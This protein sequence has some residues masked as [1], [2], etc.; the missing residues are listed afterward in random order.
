MKP[1]DPF[2]QLS[3]HFQ[4]KE[5]FTHDGTP[6]CEEHLP[7]MKDLLE[8]L[9]RARFAAN[10]LHPEAGDIGIKIISGYRHH[11]YNEKC[12]GAPNS[13]HLFTKA[14]A[15]CDFIFVGGIIKAQETWNISQQVDKSFPTRPYRLGNYIQSKGELAWVHIGC[16]YGVG[17]TRWFK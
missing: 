12:E 6:I 3:E 15:A 9:E 14:G 13:G 1:L 16:D 8:F 11:E 17:G 2:Y 5:F 4:A 7:Q 10:I